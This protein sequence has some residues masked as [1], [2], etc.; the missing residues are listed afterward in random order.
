M[1]ARI[2]ERHAAFWSDARWRAVPKGKEP[3]Q[4]FLP[5]PQD[6]RLLDASYMLSIGD[7]IYVSSPDSRKTI[8]KLTD[9]K[10][11]FTIEPGQFAF[12][13]TAEKVILPFD[14][15]GFI[16]IRAYIKF[17]GLVNISGFHVDPGYSGKLIFAVFNAG[18]SRIHLKK[19]E[20]IFSIWL[21]DLDGPIARTTTK[22][23]YDSIPTKIVN[24][25][26]GQFTTAYQL[27]EQ[28]DSIDKEVA[29]LN[30]YKNYASLVF[31]FVV[32][33]LLATFKDQLSS[34]IPK[35]LT[36]TSLTTTVPPSNTT[37]GSPSEPPT[38]AP[39]PKSA[40]QQNA[41]APEPQSPQS[42]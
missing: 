18:P 32:L 14:V 7:E 37:F 12:I 17:M 20:K 25:I 41:P 1:A 29:N 9:K 24:Q 10:P 6:E 34:F 13:L 33:I 2:P 28:I 19:G 16:S 21:T 36:S 42:K 27:K 40:P 30:A 38:R 5:S 23:G 22:V 39:T 35:A 4:P 3:I 26:S 15:I 31:A 11:N 8:Q